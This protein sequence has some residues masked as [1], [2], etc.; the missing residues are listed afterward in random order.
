MEHAVTKIREVNG[1]VEYA[2]CVIVVCVN[3]DH[4]QI[5]VTEMVQ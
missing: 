4:Y 1:V 3:Y 2:V 5:E